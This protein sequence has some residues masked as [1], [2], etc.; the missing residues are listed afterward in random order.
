MHKIYKKLFPNTGLEFNEAG[1]TQGLRN[2]TTLTKVKNFHKHFYR[3]ENIML[4][5]T[6]AV[7]IDHLFEALKET[8]EKILKQRAGMTVKPFDRPWIKAMKRIDLKKDFYSEIEFPSNTE[9][10]G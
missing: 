3:P 5:I 7:D 4:T 9:V 8:E 2:L 10:T 1:T 6:G